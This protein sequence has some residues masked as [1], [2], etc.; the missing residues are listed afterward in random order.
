MGIL[1]LCL[2]RIDNYLQ[3][4][5]RHRHRIDSDRAVFRCPYKGAKVK[6][7][8]SSWLGNLFIFRNLYCAL[9]EMQI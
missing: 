7:H 2:Q 8:R 1:D 6:M 4:I 5:L 9:A 3:E